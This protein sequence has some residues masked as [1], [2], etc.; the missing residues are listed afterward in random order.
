[1]GFLGNRLCFRARAGRG[2]DAGVAGRAF[3]F[4]YQEEL[5][6][7]PREGCEQYKPDEYI[8][9]HKTKSND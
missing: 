4:E 3:A 5:P 7:C 9:E 2:F 6:P 8:L 1:M